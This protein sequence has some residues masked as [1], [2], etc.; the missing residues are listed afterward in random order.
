MLQTFRGGSF[1]SVSSLLPLS[2]PQW[3]HSVRPVGTLPKSP[4]L[5]LPNTILFP[6]Q[7]HFSSA[8]RA[9]FLKQLSSPSERSSAG[10]GPISFGAICPALPPP[11]SLQTNHII[12]TIFSRLYLFLKYTVCLHSCCSLLNVLLLLFSLLDSYVS[13]KAHLKFYHLGKS[14]HTPCV[15]PYGTSLSFF[16]ISVNVPP[17]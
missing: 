5:G 3:N 7:T 2:L 13:F 4:S 12:W 8:A 15:L 16:T 14:Y 9:I 1:D 17:L 6:I 10:L 11:H